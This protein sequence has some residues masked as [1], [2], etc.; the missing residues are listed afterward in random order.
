MPIR[1]IKHEAV[2]ECGSLTFFGLTAEPALLFRGQSGPAPWAGTA[3]RRKQA[4][5]LARAEQDKLEPIRKSH[6]GAYL[7]R[8]V[9]GVCVMR[10][11]PSIVPET[12]DREFTWCWMI[13][14]A[15]S[16][17]PGPRPTK[18]APTAR[19]SSSI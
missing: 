7:E 10:R 12:D 4:K 19:P 8:V 2:P 17:A 11:S 5:A 1:L 9:S 18:S 15:I 3:H 6:E 13:S 16:A 14:A